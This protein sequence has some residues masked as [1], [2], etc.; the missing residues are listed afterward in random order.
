MTTRS[1]IQC[2]GLGCS[3]LPLLAYAQSVTP[4][5][6]Q[7]TWVGKTITTSTG[8]GRTFTM[9]FVADG[10]ISIAGDAF[11][12]TGT[13]RLSSDGYCVTWKQI[14]A[15]TE[16]CFTVTRFRNGEIKVS[17]PDGSASGYISKIE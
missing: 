6:I 2:L 11:A 15:G 1:R 14:R 9:K 17:N 16:R 7:D 4:K 3:L 12:D 13:W 10:S 5:E 8:T